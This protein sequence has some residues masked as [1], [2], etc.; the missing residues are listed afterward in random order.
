MAT[1]LAEY[2]W[3]NGL[4]AFTIAEDLFLGLPRTYIKNVT[5]ILAPDMSHGK[6][7][8]QNT[9]KRQIGSESLHEITEPLK[10]DNGS[11]DHLV[12]QSRSKVRQSRIQLSF[13][14]LQGWRF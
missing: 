13:E 12:Q 2:Y 6:E 11:G 10:L 9:K 4:L 7:N 3:C 14:Y 5:N 8:C 1:V